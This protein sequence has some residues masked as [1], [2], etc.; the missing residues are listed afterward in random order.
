MLKPLLPLQTLFIALLVLTGG[1]AAFA[2]TDSAAASPATSPAL[3]EGAALLPA[4]P[5]LQQHRYLAVGG[6]ALSYKGSLSNAYRNWHPGLQLGL[7]FNRKKWLNG[8]FHLS[9]GRVSGS[10]L[11]YSTSSVAGTNQANDYFRSDIFSFHY[12]ARFNLIK[13]ERFSFY[14]AGGLG[15]MRFNPLDRD[16]RALSSQPLSRAP[17]ENFNNV[18]IMLPLSVGAGYVLPNGWQLQAQA[19]WMNPQTD[20]LDNVGQLAARYGMQAGD[21]VAFWQVGLWVPF[22]IKEAP[23]RPAR[24]PRTPARQP[25]R[26]GARPVQ[27]AKPAQPAGE[28]QPAAPATAPA[29]PQG[30]QAVPESN[31]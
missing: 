11:R 9:Y 5:S 15:F 31:K 3:S 21:G 12:R 7:I 20:Y 26:A 23:A 17:G 6:M 22:Q 18:S 10:Q 29:E 14:V 2:Q 30:S 13:R 1:T 16:G 27:K 28:A 8:S 25:S 4:R 24:A 19:G